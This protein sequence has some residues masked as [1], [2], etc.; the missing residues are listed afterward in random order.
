MYYRKAYI[1]G[2]KDYKEDVEEIYRAHSFLS[3]E[4][5]FASQ[6]GYMRAKA[7]LEYE[8]VSLNNES[9]ITQ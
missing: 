8:P 1:Q 4:T 7:V 3:V 9:D 5:G 6:N 2:A